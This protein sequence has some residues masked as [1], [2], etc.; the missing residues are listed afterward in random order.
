M[1]VVVGPKSRLAG[2]RKTDLAELVMEPW[3]LSEPRSW[4][5]QTIAEAFKARRLAMPKVSLE[6]SST[7]LRVGLVAEGPYV[8]TFPTSVLRLY[9]E[10]YSIKALPVDLSVPPWP[11]AIVKLKNRTL[12]PVVDRFI[13]TLREIARSIKGGRAS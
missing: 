4:N 11:V 2:R 3:I 10:R 1:V 9:A 6:T 8:A 5:Y 12:S 7:P 13:E